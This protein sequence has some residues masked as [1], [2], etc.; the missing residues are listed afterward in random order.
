[1]DYEEILKKLE[2]FKTVGCQ[3]TIMRKLTAEK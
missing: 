2:K 3:N 1:M